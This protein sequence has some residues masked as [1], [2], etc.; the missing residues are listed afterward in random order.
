MTQSRKTASNSQTVVVLGASDKQNRYSYKA[1]QLLQKHGHVAIPVHPILKEI[2]GIQ[3]AQSLDQIKQTVDT[4]TVYVSP[5]VSARLAD[6]IVALKPGRVIFNPG[7][8]S[9][10]LSE[11][12]DANEIRFEE[13]CT[14][15]LID[16]G[17]F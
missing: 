13:A 7:A 14:L 5:A 10:E 11:I 1:L 15:V 8:E 2:D 6:E 17:Q 4:L 16:T 12:L 3:V 9:T